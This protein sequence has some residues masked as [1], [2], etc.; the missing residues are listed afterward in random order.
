MEIEYDDRF[1]INHPV[2]NR[3]YIVKI[4][5]VEGKVDDEISNNNR[6]PSHLGA[7]ILSN[8]KSKMCHVKIIKNAIKTSSF[9]QM[10]T[11]SIYI[12]TNSFDKPDK[13]SYVAK[14]L[15]Q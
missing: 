1:E 7:F 13:A 3:G 14:E 8:S 2:R 4:R 6:K 12:Q 15:G 9:F 10:D 11:D 5:N